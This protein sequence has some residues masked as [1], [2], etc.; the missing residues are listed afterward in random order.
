[1]QQK[2][3]MDHFIIALA[4]NKSDI[5]KSEWQ[6]TDDMMSD[7]KTKLNLNDALIEEHTSARTG[8]GVKELFLNIA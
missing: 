3:N 8:E 2:N 6:I 1:M 7:L 5:P 4:G